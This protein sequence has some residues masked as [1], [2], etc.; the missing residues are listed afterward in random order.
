MV[1][2]YVGPEENTPPPVCGQFL[3]N[4]GLM[5]P[6]YKDVRVEDAEA[7]VQ[8]CRDDKKCVAVSYKGRGGCWLRKEFSG[9][10]SDPSKTTFILCDGDEGVLHIEQETNVRVLIFRALAK[11][12]FCQNR[13]EN[14]DTSKSERPSTSC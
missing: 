10:K 5:A 4:T 8:R 1:L 9:V 13:N 12:N 3:P 6:G 14:S 2:R 7:C 11:G